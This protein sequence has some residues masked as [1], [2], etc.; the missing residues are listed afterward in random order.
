L[1]IFRSQFYKDSI[2][3]MKGWYEAA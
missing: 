1:K 3:K 2:A